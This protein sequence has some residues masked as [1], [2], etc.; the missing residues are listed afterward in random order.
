MNPLWRNIR[1]YIWT[2]SE[3]LTCPCKKLSVEYGTYLQVNYTLHPVCS[4]IFVNN[5]F[6]V[7]LFAQPRNQTLFLRDFRGIGEH[8]FFTLIS[9]CQLMDKI[10]SAGLIRFYSNQHVSTTVISEELF[11]LEAQSSFQQ[12]IANYDKSSFVI[13]ANLAWYYSSQRFIFWTTYQ[14]WFWCNSYTS[15]FWSCSF[16]AFCK[17]NGQL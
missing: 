7:Q 12:F 17:R 1:N 14:L 6:L 10:L 9:L 3:V 8:M 2:Y 5:E 4:S 15:L 11:H 16:P 13:N